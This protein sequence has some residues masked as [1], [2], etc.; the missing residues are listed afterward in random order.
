MLR[1]HGWLRVSGFK[2]EVQAK[3]INMPMSG[4]TLFGSEVD[5]TLEQLK[6][7]S[8]VMKSMGGCPL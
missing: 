7:D 6:K 5:A 1:R 2:P 8:K 4:K 3:V